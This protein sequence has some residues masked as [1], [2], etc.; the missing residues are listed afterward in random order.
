MDEKVDRNLGVEGSNPD[1]DC[2]FCNIFRTAKT[3][4]S[5]V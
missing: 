3:G 1:S 4:D 5:Y 2:P